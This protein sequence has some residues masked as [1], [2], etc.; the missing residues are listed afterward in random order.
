MKG[1]GSK[2]D[3]VFNLKTCIGLNVTSLCGHFLRGGDHRI[4][5]PS[6]A[7]GD[8]DGVDVQ[9]VHVPVV[10]SYHSSVQSA[11]ILGNVSLT[12]KQT[13]TQDISN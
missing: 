8:G 2:L 4:A 9:K 6:L 3:P 11:R 13:A 1:S 5:A 7:T 10:S 12:A